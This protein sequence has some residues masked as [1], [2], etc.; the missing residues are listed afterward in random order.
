M[1]EDGLPMW[2]I[3]MPLAWINWLAGTGKTGKSGVR[4]NGYEEGVEK[5]EE[6]SVDLE[7]DDAFMFNGSVIES[8]ISSIPHK[9]SNHRA[10]DGMM[11]WS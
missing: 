1:R 2:R 7:A 5:V 9:P 10:K 8:V 11:D 3:L 6:A 4:G